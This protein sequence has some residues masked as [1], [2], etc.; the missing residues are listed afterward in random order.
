MKIKACNKQIILKVPKD[1]QLETNSG[2]VLPPTAI[3]SEKPHQGIVYMSDHEDYATGEVVMYRKY[4]GFEFNL[5]GD[6]FLCIEAS[7][8][9][10]KLIDDGIATKE[11]VKEE[12]E[13]D[14][15]KAAVSNILST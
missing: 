5:N 9:L 4:S 10:I 1:K 11:V 3:G 2:L 7:D 12:S 8:V 13:W 6:E 15:A 14:K